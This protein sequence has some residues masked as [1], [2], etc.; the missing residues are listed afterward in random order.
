MLYVIIVIIL[1]TLILLVKMFSNAVELFQRRSVVQHPLG[2]NNRSLI[3]QPADVQPI[4]FS[5]TVKSQTEGGNQ[6]NTGSTEFN[7]ACKVG[8]NTEKVCKLFFDDARSIP[9]F[10]DRLSSKGLDMPNLHQT[11]VQCKKE[12]GSQTPPLLKK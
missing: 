11:P 12:Y 9:T 6:Y 4:R 5:S 1:T 2:F 8:G 3:V 10:S 7:N